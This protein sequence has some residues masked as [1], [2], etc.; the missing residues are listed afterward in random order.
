[1]NTS[2]GWLFDEPP[3]ARPAHPLTSHLAASDIRPH[4]AKLHRWAAQCVRE[5]P[6]LTQRELGAKYCPLDPRKIG[7]R[8]C[9][10]ERMGWIKRG[11]SRRCTVSKH[12]AETW[13]PADD[14]SGNGTVPCRAVT[15]P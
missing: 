4:V 2:D 10:I 5:S 13:W 6:G 1:V 8:L 9:E 15:V 12:P 11:G 7:R 3:L 14:E